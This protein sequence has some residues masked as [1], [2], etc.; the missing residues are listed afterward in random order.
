[1]GR[2]RNP[3]RPHRTSQDHP[4]RQ[5]GLH[6]AGHGHRR[7]HR[8]TT[9]TTR[10]TTQMNRRT[11]LAVAISALAAAW[12]PHGPASA[13]NAAHFFLPDGTCHEVGSNTRRPD[14][15]CRQPQPESRL[16]QPARTARPD[17][18]QRRPV[19]RPLRRRP[20]PTTAPRQLPLS[21][22]KQT[23][24]PGPSST[25]PGSSQGG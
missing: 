2:R 11:T 16:Q 17:P 13:H 19:R 7:Q 10:R 3:T 18:R 1:M 6:G 5:P 15:R 8:N 25:A 24:I 20:Q 14:R 4:P 12:L 23:P 22:T 21:V 9:N